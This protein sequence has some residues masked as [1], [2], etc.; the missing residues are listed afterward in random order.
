MPITLM[1]SRGCCREHLA[2]SPLSRLRIPQARQIVKIHHRRG[3]IDI[4]EVAN[5][6]CHSRT[7]K[8]PATFH[9]RVCRNAWKCAAAPARPPPFHFSRFAQVLLSPGTL[10]KVSS[11]VGVYRSGKKVKCSRWQPSFARWLSSVNLGA[12]LQLGVLSPTI[13]ARIDPAA[14]VRADAAIRCSLCMYPWWCV[15]M[16]ICVFVWAAASRME[17]RQP[18]HFQFPISLVFCELA[19]LFG[20]SAEDVQSDSKVCASSYSRKFCPA[21]W[22]GKSSSRW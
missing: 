12:V 17:S 19:L 8:P 20:F 15:R 1:R 9:A 16:C 5:P 7:Q 13:Q 21:Q 10:G 2:L 4:Q 14:G 3:M 11:V 22:Q 18:A 6:L